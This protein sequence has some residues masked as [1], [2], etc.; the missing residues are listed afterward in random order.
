M[1]NRS[2][3]RNVVASA[4]A[5]GAMG[6]LSASA[7]LVPVPANGDIFLGFRATGG[8]GGDSAYLVNL[9]Q[10]T[11]F[12]NA[13]EGSSFTLITIG[14]TGAD[15]VA[16]YG[17]D[18]STR[19]DLSWGVFGVRNSSSPGVY[20]SKARI[21]PGTASL[22]WPALDL[23]S[24]SSVTT[25]VLSVIENIGGY[26]G[27]PFTANSPVAALQPNGATPSSY[28]FQTGTA[29]TTDFGSPSQW[30]SIEGNFATGISGAALDLY[31]I[32]GSSTAPVQNLGYFTISSGGVITFTR[33]APNANVDTDGDGWLDSDEVIA[34]TNPNDANDFFRVQEVLTPPGGD[35]VVKFQGVAGRNYELQF[36]ET[37]AAGSWVFVA[38][39]T[40]APAGPAQL[41]D[42]DSGRRSKPKGFYR[43]VV[44]Q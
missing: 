16:T 14:N 6:L 15:L 41:S 24:R 42:N 37:L 29:G 38:S 25:Q 3:A 26:R 1:N 18:W 10:D 12:R 17:S 32:T 13:A 40:S 8:Q 2:F 22:P 30:S 19:A 36:S 34:G 44:S 21:S 11:Q 33:P 28:A 20:G 5:A 7:Q 39:L 31:R 23:N 35:A 27:R 9:G 43:V 4:F